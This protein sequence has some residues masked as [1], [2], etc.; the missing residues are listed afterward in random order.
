MTLIVPLFWVSAVTTLRAQIGGSAI[1]HWTYSQEIYY[2]NFTHGHILFSFCHLTS[3]DQVFG[4]TCGFKGV[5]NSP[6]VTN[7]TTFMAISLAK[8]DMLRFSLS[9]DHESPRF[10]RIMWLH[11]WVPLTKSPQPPILGGHRPCRRGD[12]KVSI[13]HV[14]SRDHVIRE[15]SDIMDEFPS[16]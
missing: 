10:Q 11:R 5:F 13:C 1:F 2:S 4:G 7:L 15:S 8:E 14:T 16:S 3:C 9:R 12:I 6:W